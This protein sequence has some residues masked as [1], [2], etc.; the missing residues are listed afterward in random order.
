MKFPN[1]AILTCSI[2]LTGCLSPKNIET[3]DNVGH[4]FR[5]YVIA[6]PTVNAAE[7]IGHF[8]YLYYKGRKLSQTNRFTVAPSGQAVVY[9]DGPSG[10]IFLFRR[11]GE[12]TTQ[13]TSTFPGLVQ[14]FN[15]NESEHYFTALIVNRRGIVQERKFVI[16]R[17]P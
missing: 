9:Q 10:N 16:K 14:S 15:W 12:S 4:G 11:E 3:T 5:H 17:A 2:L 13:L 8:D 1:A 6:E 7:S